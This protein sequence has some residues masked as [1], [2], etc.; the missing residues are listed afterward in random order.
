[1]SPKRVWKVRAWPGGAGQLV[2]AGRTEE[3]GQVGLFLRGLLQ[4]VAFQTP[5][6]LE[7]LFFQMP[8]VVLTGPQARVQAGGQTLLP[9]G[10]TR[11]EGFVTAVGRNRNAAVFVQA[12]GLPLLQLEHPLKK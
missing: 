11:P 9:F 7:N 10:H 1:M 6:L 3:R 12:L 5:G 2:S 8:Q 4:E